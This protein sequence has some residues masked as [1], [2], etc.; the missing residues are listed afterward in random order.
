[1][2]KEPVKKLVVSLAIPSIISMLITM[3][4]NSADSFFVSMVSGED[5]ATTGSIG[6]VLSLMSLIQ[7]IGFFFGHGT[8]NYS[9]RA[10]GRGEDDKAKD[11]ASTGFFSAL[12]FGVLFSVIAYLLLPEVVTLLGATPTILPYAISYAKYIVLAAPFYMGAYVLNIQLRFEGNASVGTIGIA[13]GGILNIVLDAVFILGLGMGVEG[14]GLGTLIGQVVGFGTMLI[15]KQ[16]FGLARVEL[17]R[18]KPS[19]VLYRDMIGGGLPSLCRQGLTAIA[20]ATLCNCAGVYGD[21]AIAGMSA[22][23]K[24][25]GIGGSLIIG[26]SQGFQPV[27]GFSY[28]AGLYDRVREGF[29]F[30]V[31][32]GLVMLLV[33]SVVGIVF[34]EDLVRAFASDPSAV[35]FGATA[36]RIQCVS[37]PLASYIV[38]PNMSLQTMG[39]TLYATILSAARQGLIFIPCVLI[40][41][42]FL[43]ELGV[44]GSQVVADILTFLISIPIMR[45]TWREIDK[46]KKNVENQ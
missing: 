5:S 9:S 35:S 33:I 42:L 17:S 10:F 38:G 4:Y 7:A 32:T 30:S 26:F 14:A 18:F 29:V 1:M 44:Q 23:N 36:M 31:K 21:S 25:M 28:G 2:T 8:G 16:R 6:V 39:K 19:R 22:V 41:P 27:C 24:V 3:I 40:L 43:G 34:A 45:D 46:L 11:M 15:V 12:I 13:V 37:F 20:F